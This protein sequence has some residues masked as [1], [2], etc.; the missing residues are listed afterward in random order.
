VDDDCCAPEDENQTCQG[1]CGPT[2]NNCGEEI[3]CPDCGNGFA[4]SDL[5]EG[6]ICECP[7]P[8]DECAGVCCATG[9]VCAA[10]TTTC[11][12]AYQFLA[13]WGELSECQ[14]PDCD[15]P[16]FD[17][18]FNK[19]RGITFDAGGK[20]YVVDQDNERVQK[21]E[22]LDDD[23]FTIGFVTKFGS[24]GFAS[25]Q[26]LFPYGIEVD[27]DGIVSVSDLSHNRIQ[28][29]RKISDN[30]ETYGDPDN[31]P[32]PCGGMTQPPCLSQPL[33]TARD[34]D[35][36][37]YVTDSLGDRVRK[38]NS[39]GTTQLLSFDGS[40]GGS[41]AFNEPEGIGVDSLDNVYVVDRQRH[42]VRKFT[43]AGVLITQWGAS[44]D[45]NGAF[46][47]PEGLAIDSND[48]VYVADTAN[49]RIQKFA[50]D[51]TFV[52]KWGV[53]GTGNGQ[54]QGPVGVA[55]D[56]VG[57]VFV[58]DTQNHRIQV[59]APTPV[60]APLREAGKTAPERKNRGP[61]GQ[62]SSG[63]RR[64]VGRERRRDPRRKRQRVRGRNRRG[65]RR[66]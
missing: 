20:I 21:F 9:L 41:S 47:F 10:A 5:A 57:N 56:E 11:S 55:V 16:A 27:A 60:A 19:P 34:S 52:T 40:E 39:T 7:A 51:G 48:D 13:K 12:A 29:W 63:N 62:P 54:F 3:D 8:R 46:N 25:D 32:S 64:K 24:V 2:I 43:S 50:S 49:N 23:P 59:F 42:R 18:K 61:D 35:G 37:V 30:P 1:K 17:G 15:A 44:G 6:G 28:R 45:T 33:F 36:N 65:G 31:W 38:F 14:Q 22:Q 66:R 53:P 26:F 4:C 58:T